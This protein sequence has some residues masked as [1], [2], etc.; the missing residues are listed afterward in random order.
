MVESGRV[1]ERSIKMYENMEIEA[2]IMAIVIFV[3]F[4]AAY[5]RSKFEWLFGRNCAKLVDL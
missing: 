5:H 2:V 4:V 1:D 3:S